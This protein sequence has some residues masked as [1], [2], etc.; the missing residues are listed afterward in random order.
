MMQK[1][2]RKF[3]AWKN[4]KLG[5]LLV[6]FKTMQFYLYASFRKLTIAGNSLRCFGVLIRIKIHFGLNR[7]EISDLSDI[8]FIWSRK[9]HWKQKLFETISSSSRSLFFPFSMKYLLYV[10]TQKIIILRNKYWHQRFS[11]KNK[12]KWDAIFSDFSLTKLLFRLLW[13][14][15]WVNPI[16]LSGI[17]HLYHAVSLFA[18]KHF[19]NS[20]I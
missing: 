4:K 15:L 5:A 20:H 17:F 1:W 19:R 18:T 13:N 10:S 9:E 2:F 14:Y 3:W 6:S 16:C 12:T 7:P 11:D 8:N